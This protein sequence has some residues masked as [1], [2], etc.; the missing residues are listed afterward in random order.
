MVFPAA[1]ANAVTAGAIRD[2]R[3]NV[4]EERD[5]RRDDQ[6]TEYQPTDIRVVEQ[7]AE[8]EKRG[9]QARR[10]ESQ[11]EQRQDGPDPGGRRPP[12][13]RGEA[14]PDLRY[15]K[16]SDHRQALKHALSGVSRDYADPE[17]DQDQSQDLPDRQ[18][19]VDNDGEPARVAHSLGPLAPPG[20]PRKQ[21]AR[22][23]PDR[24]ALQKPSQVVG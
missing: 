22:P 20:E 18:R 19:S 15:V 14:D 3:D 1:L 12:R 16:D 13:E 6:E 7:T 24:F 11:I 10:H 4:G 2:E 23:C 21:T 5:T 17:G 8:G 9:Q